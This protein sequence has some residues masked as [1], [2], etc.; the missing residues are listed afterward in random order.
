MAERVE[1]RAKPGGAAAG[2]DVKG[3]AFGDNSS[4][5]YIEERHIHNHPLPA[6]AVSWPVQVGSVPALASAFQSRAELRLRVDAAR[7]HGETVV[8]TQVLSGGGGVGKTQLAAAYAAEAMHGGADLVVWVPAGEEHT[9]VTGYAGAA[10]RVRA[11]GATGEDSVGDARAFLDWLATTHRRWLVVLDDI[12][13]LQAVQAWWP[14]SHTGTGWVLATTRLHDARLTGGGRRR[15]DVDVYTPDEAVAYLRSRLDGDGLVHL[16]DEHA[17]ALA[18]A[19]GH[20]PLAL[21]HAAA[22]MINLDET[23]TRYLRLFNDRIHTLDQL[24]PRTADTEGYGRAIS[25]TLL[26]ALDAADR[27]HP[28]GLATPMLRLAALL[29]PAGHPEDLWTTPAA[30]TH[31]TTHRH[32]VNV[33]EAAPITPE[34]ARTMLRTLHRYALLS[35]DAG[36]GS[37]AVRIHALTA[38]AAQEATSDSALPDLAAAAADALAQV[39][40]EPDRTWPALAIE[41]RSNTDALRHHAGDLLWRPEGHAILFRAGD[42]LLDAGLSNAA[43]GYW[44]RMEADAR[45]LL[46][47]DHPDTLTACGSLAISLRDMG[48]LEEA[49]AL[50]MRV[51]ADSNRLR[52]PDHPSTVTARANL[53]VTYHAAGR[54]GEAIEL[55][56]AVLADCERLL[57]LDHLDTLLARANLA[58]SYKE[59]DRLGEAIE[60]QEAVLADRERLLGL[61]HPHTLLAR[62]N[63]AVCYRSAGRL[64]EAI[65]IHARVL[66]DRE[67]LLGPDHPDT[68][69]AQGNLAASYQAA[70]RLEEAIAI[71]V[72]VLADREALLGPDHPDTLLARANLAV[73]YQAADCSSMAVDLKERVLADSDRLLGSGHPDTIRARGNL[74][75]SYVKAGRTEE[76]VELLEQEAAHRGRLQGPDHPSALLARSN[77]AGTY[78]LAGRTA[79]AIELHEAVLADR[80]RLLGPD[81]PDTHSTRVNLAASYQKAG[82]LEEAIDLLERVIADNQPLQSPGYRPGPPASS[83]G[84]AP[85]E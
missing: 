1:V 20:L 16:L 46:G 15:V 19:L 65:A 22:Y 24:L 4:V 13:D 63:L 51:L 9:V 71:E 82:R 42:S 6:E 39:W 23:C 36:A 53:A 3:N 47:A 49:A 75:Y 80:E 34:Q 41:L 58:A 35:V 84:P 62:A 72:R 45:R 67:A 66:A 64:E 74:A 7:S 77:L 27:A 33:Q 68:L 52:G 14:A 37:R 11:P 73:T 61:D 31:L 2:R 59:A 48:R 60:L 29:D 40:P 44:Q 50:E 30:L 28:H 56:E 18:E 81:H 70:G 57:G 78:Q 85:T 8:L 79:D 12:A 55:Q 10:S 83:P 54:L 76:A 5:T 38:R 26:L 43:V 21:G 32:P 69:T 25:T 17:G